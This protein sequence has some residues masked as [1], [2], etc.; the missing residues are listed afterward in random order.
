MGKQLEQLSDERRR[1]IS[2]YMHDNGASSTSPPPEPVKEAK[3][4]HPR[5]EVLP[6]RSIETPPKTAKA[7]RGRSKPEDSAASSTSTPPGTVDA[8]RGSRSKPHVSTAPSTSTPLGTAKPAR[9]SRPTQEFSNVPQAP[10]QP[11]PWSVEP[12]HETR[13]ER[14]GQRLVYL[15]RR[16]WRES[17]AAALVAFAVAIGWLVAH[18]AS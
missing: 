18:G 17:S 9:A 16:F 2:R 12:I 5:P 1:L 13:S 7:P 10:R 15:R 6:T 8:P 4:S 11:N 3:A 14:F